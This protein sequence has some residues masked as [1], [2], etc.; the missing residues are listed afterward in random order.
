MKKSKLG[1]FSISIPANTSIP[2]NC[3][4]CVKPPA[5]QKKSI[6]IEG[7]LQNGTLALYIAKEFFGGGE[8]VIPA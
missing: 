5:P 7:G 2:A 4:P 1:S 3:S 8:Y 6:A